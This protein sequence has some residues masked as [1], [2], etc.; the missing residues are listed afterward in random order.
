M[1][2]QDVRFSSGDGLIPAIIQ[3]TQS[4]DVL[5]LG[6]MNAES[7]KLSMETGYVYFYSRSRGMLWKKGEISGNTLRIEGMSIDCDGDALRV[8][9]TVCGSAVCH[10]GNRSCFYRQL[11]R[12]I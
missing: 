12:D 7:L 8:E 5:M 11:G 4:R 9:V 6:Y 2:S 1:T 3:D 10:T